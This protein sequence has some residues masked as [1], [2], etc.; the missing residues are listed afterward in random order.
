MNVINSIGISSSV[1]AK[2]KYNYKAK[3]SSD[4][5]E[6]SFRKREMIVV[7]CE[8]ES[9]WMKGRNEAGSTGWFPSSAVQVL[10]QERPQVSESFH[11][12][13]SGS[14]V[15]GNPTS[16]LK[17]IKNE[18]SSKKDVPRSVSG[19]RTHKE[20]NEIAEKEHF[21]N[22]NEAKGNVELVVKDGN[23]LSLNMEQLEP[24]VSKIT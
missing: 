18:A 2:A 14:S 10:S 23:S 15:E 11:N 8:D 16:Q 17:S 6:I 9:G 20:G 21:T 12:N 5:Q 1:T 4:R 13:G 22:R 19:I 24:K 7:L 3:E